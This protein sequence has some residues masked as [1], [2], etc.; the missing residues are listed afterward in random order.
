MDTSA[1]TALTFAASFRTEDLAVIRLS[2]CGE[3]LAHPIVG[4]GQMLSQRPLE[5]LRTTGLKQFQQF[6]MLIDKLMNVGVCSRRYRQ[7]QPDLPLQ[8]PIEH[9]QPMA[10]DTFYKGNVKLTIR[11]QDLQVVIRLDQP[12]KAI[13][14]PL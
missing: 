10:A 12:T 5:V 1:R 3:G 11:F 6:G 14:G 8:P 9:R 7:A 4:D 13:D 2:C